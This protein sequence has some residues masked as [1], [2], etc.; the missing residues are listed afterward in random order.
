MSPQRTRVAVFE[1]PSARAQGAAR[2]SEPAS[3]GERASEERARIKECSESRSEKR[4]GWGGSALIVVFAAGFALG[5]L[6][7]PASTAGAQSKRRV[8]EIRTYT[9]NEGKLA[10]LHA[11]FRNHT[12]RLFEKHGMT[13][14]GYW[15]PQD[16]PLAEN[17]L[18]YVIS[19]ESREAAKANWDGFRQDPGWQK[20]QAESEAKGKLV[21][22]V[23]SIFMDA[24]DYS[25]MK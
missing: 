13:N 15:S 22:K 7:G 18:I 20:V 19:H 8:F 17:T 23:D 10:D 11:R 4:W 1:E 25:P 9:A 5:N 2:R 12:L 24:T 16:A 21:A 14:V 6:F 3:G